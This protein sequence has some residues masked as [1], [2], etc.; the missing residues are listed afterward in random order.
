MVASLRQL[1]ACAM[2][3][4]A[5]TFQFT[6]A[7]EKDSVLDAVTKKFDSLLEP[8]WKFWAGAAVGFVGSRLALSSAVTAVKVAGVAFVAYV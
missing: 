6:S 1:F 7:Q 4:F 3:V 2:V 5:L 8:G